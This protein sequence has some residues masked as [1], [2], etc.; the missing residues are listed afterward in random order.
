MVAPGDA[1]AAVIGVGLLAKDAVT[2]LSRKRTMEQTLTPISRGTL[3]LRKF[4][5][6][7]Q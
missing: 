6:V 3:L 1:T 2:S 4:V 5:I 7:Q